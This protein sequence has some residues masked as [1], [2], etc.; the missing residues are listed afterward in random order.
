MN[1]GYL[2]ISI[3]INKSIL[4]TNDFVVRQTHDLNSNENNLVISPCKDA[5]NR[6]SN[7]CERH[8]KCTLLWLIVPILFA[9]KK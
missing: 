9:L 3:N 4:D 7:I 2:E 8:Y 5:F 6:S 1:L